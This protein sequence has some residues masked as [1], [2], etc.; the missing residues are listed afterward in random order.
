MC[1]CTVKYEKRETIP[2]LNWKNLLAK[3]YSDI[4]KGC[5]CLF[6]LSEIDSMPYETAIIIQRN[7]DTHL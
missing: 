6:V 2:H 3:L 7:W 1:G 4:Y 5:D